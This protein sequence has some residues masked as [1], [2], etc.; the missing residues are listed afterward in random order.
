MYTGI[1][2]TGDAGEMSPSLLEMANF[3]PHHFALGLFVKKCSG[4]S[5][6]NELYTVRRALF[7]QE[8]LYNLQDCFGVFLVTQVL[9]LG[10][11]II[12]VC[13]YVHYVREALNEVVVF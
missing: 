8:N 13:L 4:N 10:T 12:S 7:A 3:V 11:A 6:H 9:Q 2:Y 1:I 5:V